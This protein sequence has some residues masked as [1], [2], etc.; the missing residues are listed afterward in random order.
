MKVHSVVISS[1]AIVV[2]ALAFHSGYLFF[3]SFLF[4][5]NVRNWFIAVHSVRRSVL[6]SEK[7]SQ[8]LHQIPET[9]QE[10]QRPENIAAWS[11]CLRIHSPLWVRWSFVKVSSG[12]ISVYLTSPDHVFLAA[13]RSFSNSP[14]LVTEIS[15]LLFALVRNQIPFCHRRPRHRTKTSHLPA[16]CWKELLHGAVWFSQWLNLIKV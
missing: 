4:F 16:M 15:Q 13:F 10:R 9:I 3:L 14:E 11:D 8:E 12:L 5:D 7:F 1:I 2:V 6:L